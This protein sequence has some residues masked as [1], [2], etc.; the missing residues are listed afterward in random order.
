MEKRF[1]EWNQQKKRVNERHHAP[2][3]HE[4][5]IWWCTVGV[6]VGTKQ[7]GTGMA[8]T[9]PVLV[10]KSLGRST[11]LAIPL[12]TSQKAHPLRPAIGNVAGKNAHALLSQL[13]VVDAKRLVRKIGNLDRSVFA[14]MRKTAKDML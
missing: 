3:Y 10:L 4:R 5:E 11:F 12:T 6:N 9:R 1:D 2:F 14:Q 13:R 7:D 8:F